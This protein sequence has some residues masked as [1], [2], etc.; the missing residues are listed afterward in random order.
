MSITRSMRSR[1][2]ALNS[3]EASRPLAAERRHSRMAA[4]NTEAMGSGGR[5]PMRSNRS[6]SEPPDQNDSSNCLARE[7][8][9]RRRM[10][11]PKMIV[12]L[13]NEARISSTT[14]HWTMMSALRNSTEMVMLVSGCTVPCS[15]CVSIGPAGT[16]CMVSDWI[17][18]VGTACWVVLSCASCVAIAGAYSLGWQE[19]GKRRTQRGRQPR[20]SSGG[21]ETGERDGHRDEVDTVAPHDLLEVQRG[22]GEAGHAGRDLQQIVEPR[23]LPI[24]DRAA[25]HDE[26]Q[27]ACAERVG[28]VVAELTQP[29]AARAL[30]EFQIVRVV[31]DTGGVRILV[32][33]AHGKAVRRC[34]RRCRAT[35]AACRHAIH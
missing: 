17:G 20:R 31:D 9:R 22:A 35:G 8:R 26:Q 32:V 27:P 14:T 5:S 2:L 15:S 10:I 3:L 33:D 23:R 16:A 30:G 4:T 34:Q 18:V 6:S 28:L 13:Q 29:L 19:R 1:K 21:I 12:Q 25:P 11:F 7:R 24:V